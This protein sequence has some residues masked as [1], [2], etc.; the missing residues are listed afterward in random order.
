VACIAVGSVGQVLL[1]E[2]LSAS[3]DIRIIVG[4]AYAAAGALLFGLALDDELFVAGFL[5]IAFGL[6]V[7][8]GRTLLLTCVHVASPESHRHHVLSLYIFVTAAATPVGALVWGAVADALS[9]DATLGGAGVLVMF[10]IGAGLIAILRHPRVAAPA[11][12]A[13]TPGR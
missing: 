1:V 2:R 7:S 5:L 4:I 10:G 8:M 9:I 12:A 13:E 3:H 6:A 11:A